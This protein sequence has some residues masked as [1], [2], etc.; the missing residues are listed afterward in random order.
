MCSEIRIYFEGHR[1]LKPGFSL[2]FSDLRDLATRRRCKF[3]LI[4]SKSGEEACRDFETALKTHPSAWNILLKD[5][6]GPFSA[7]L[8]PNLCNRRNWKKS[9][10]NSI[11]WMVEMMEAWF[12]ADID[13]VA[14]YYGATFKRNA[15]KPNP[16]VEAI[17][18]RDLTSGL[19]RATKDTPK[20]DYFEHKTEHGPA[21]LAVINPA[22]VCAAAQNCARL[23]NS[24]REKLA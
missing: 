19:K 2:F 8:A 9:S 18:K 22:L 4:A 7:Q 14:D 11:F 23:F 12:H 17:S 15:L 24:V 5:S 1:L 21:L 3:E 10:A 6:E 16:A 13:K 20:G